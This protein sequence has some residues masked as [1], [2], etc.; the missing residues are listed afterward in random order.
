M[1]KAVLLIAL[2]LF[3][4]SQYKEDFYNNSKEIMLRTSYINED[5]VSY[6]G[7]KNHKDYII[8]ATNKKINQIKIDDE[9]QEF[10]EIP[11]DKYNL[12][13]KNIF[14]KFYEISKNESNKAKIKIE[15]IYPDNSTSISL[16]RI[17]KS[18]DYHL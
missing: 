15:I 9:E 2:F 17:S 10:V 12:P 13:Y 1:K 18:L 4:C 11:K 6:L 16:Q 5:I 14:I 3:S 8:L 7:V